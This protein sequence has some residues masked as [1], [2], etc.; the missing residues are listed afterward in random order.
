MKINI[1]CIILA[2]GMSSRMSKWKV[3]LP[4]KGKTIIERCV[5]NAL[6]ICKRVILVVG[7]RSSELKEK[8]RN[9]RD[10]FI[11]ENYDYK[12]GMFKSIQTGVSS[13]QTDYFFISH[14]D[15]PLVSSQVYKTL[16]EHKGPEAVIPVHNG[17]KGHPVL[18][19][20]SIIGRVLEEQENSSMKKLLSTY[21]KQLVPVDTKGIYKDIDTDEDY[22]NLLMFKE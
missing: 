15:L 10:I 21:P 3:Q 4:F 20:K 18:L 2:A 6:L 13:V 1:D 12:K 19:P 7:Y 22:K 11:I 9:G 8:F 16:A 17:R 5:S 14:G